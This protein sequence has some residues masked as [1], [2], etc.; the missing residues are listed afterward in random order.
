MKPSDVTWQ[1][2]RGP[3]GTTAYRPEIIHKRKKYQGAAMAEQSP[4]L[5]FGFIQLVRRHSEGKR[6]AAFDCD[7]VI[8]IPA[9]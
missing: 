1:T 6:V 7:G 8:K 4:A 9:Q 2:V 5:A 3:N